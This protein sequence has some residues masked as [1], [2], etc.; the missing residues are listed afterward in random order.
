VKEFFIK[1]PIYDVIVKVTVGDKSLAPDDAGQAMVVEGG[2]YW[3]RVRQNRR[4]GDEFYAS[5]GHEL[6]HVVFEILDR[7][8]MAMC[9]P[10]IEAYCY[11]SGFLQ[12]EIFKKL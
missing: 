8:G 7:A 9:R 3:L 1:V 2:C 6:Q 10:T 12:K 5:L 4:D 11:L